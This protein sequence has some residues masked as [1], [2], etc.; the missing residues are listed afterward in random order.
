MCFGSCPATKNRQGHYPGELSPSPRTR[1]WNNLVHVLFINLV[2]LYSLAS[3]FFDLTRGFGFSA[4]RSPLITLILCPK[5]L[6]VQPRR[7][8]CRRLR[9]LVGLC[10]LCCH[11]GRSRLRGPSC[12]GLGGRISPGPGCFGHDGRGCGRRIPVD[13]TSVCDRRP[14]HPVHNG[15]N[16]TRDETSGGRSVGGGLQGVKHLPKE[17]SIPF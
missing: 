8:R 5:L 15:P 16:N 4:Q 11:R 7:G 10:C 14:P 17:F 9:V 1:K 12:D 13:V 2:N 6:R 3:P